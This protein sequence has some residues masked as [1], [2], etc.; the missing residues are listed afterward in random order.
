MGGSRGSP[1]SS[2]ENTG[3]PPVPRIVTIKMHN[4]L[5]YRISVAQHLLLGALALLICA[6]FFLAATPSGTAPAIVPPTAQSIFQDQ[7]TSIEADLA[8]YLQRRL[9]ATGPQLA[10]IDFQIDLRLLQRWMLACAADAKTSE[11]VQACVSLRVL[12][13][14]SV[15]EQVAQRLQSAALNA[16]QL[17]GL[18]K[19]HR[20]TYALPDVADVKAIDDMCRTVAPA[21]ILAANATP[22]EV[23]HLPPMRPLP[24]TTPAPPAEPAQRTLSELTA[25]AKQ[26]QVSPALKRQLIALAGAATSAASAAAA[27]DP[28]AQEHKAQEEAELLHHT[29]IAVTELSDGIEKSTGIDAAARA[30]VE[31]QLTE[32]LALFTDVRTRSTGKQRLVALGQYRQTLIRVQQLHL[33]AALLQKLA[34]AFVWVNNNPEAGGK[35]LEAIEKYVKL[36]GRYDARKESTPLPPNQR[37]TLDGLVKQFVAHRSAFLDDAAELGGATIFSPGP[38][39]VVGHVETMRQLFETIDLLDK[40]PRA[41][42]VLNPYHPRPG[43]GLEKRMNVAVA[44]LAVTAVSGSRDASLRFCTD[45]EH[46][47]QL[48]ERITAPTGIPADTIKAYTNGRLA[49][50]ETRRAAIISEL[51]S[52][53]ASSRDMDSSL[54]SK[55]DVLRSLYESLHLANDVETGLAKGEQLKRWADWSINPAQLRALVNPYR[56]A[57]A[58][59]FDGF[60]IDNATPIY[61]WPDVYKRFAPILALVKEVGQYADQMKDL[62]TGLPGEFSKLLTPMDNQPFALERYA[63]FAVGVWQ[64]AAEATDAKSADGLFDAMLVRLRKE[65]RVE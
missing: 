1:M 17:E 20:L 55:L 3:G 65:L 36:C 21:M 57:T 41:I 15:G 4:K 5:S 28:K 18:A 16:S 22:A 44:D 34:P 62:P 7:V 32:G 40:L 49:A 30:K 47:A 63:S 2:E 64:R 43:G 6:R 14:Q 45:V 13:L 58:A 50:V 37:K 52:S 48:A 26:V 27:E 54:L 33:P 12:N 25:R 42:Q 61:R 9:D 53:L 29:L 39:N 51:A 24:I 59:A 11:E 31:Q 19:L 35:I 38:A 10:V 23:K 56:D 46:L 8:T 60:V